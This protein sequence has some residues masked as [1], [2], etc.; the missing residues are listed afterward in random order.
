LSLR[1]PAWWAKLQAWLVGE[2]QALRGWLRKDQTQNWLTN[3]GAGALITWLALVF[4]LDEHLLPKTLFFVIALLCVALTLPLNLRR[5]KVLISS[6]ASY[7]KLYWKFLLI[8]CMVVVLTLVVER[9]LQPSTSPDFPER[10]IVREIELAIS[11]GDAQRWLGLEEDSKRP[12]MILSLKGYEVI[13]TEDPSDN[14]SKVYIKEGQK[15]AEDARATTPYSFARKYYHGGCLFAT[16]YCDSAGH[17]VVTE[18][19]AKCGGEVKIYKC[20][21]PVLF[22][23]VPV[24]MYR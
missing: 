9:L 3:S 18:Y 15:I 6:V 10:Q 23:P 22:P 11:K 1:A 13:E 20:I 14:V 17:C 21:E 2:G 4:T 8:I 19:Q 24:F 16:D 7:F 5:G 12:Q